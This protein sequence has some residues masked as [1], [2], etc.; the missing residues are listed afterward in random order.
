MKKKPGGSSNEEKRFAVLRRLVMIGQPATFMDLGYIC[1]P[2]TIRT[3]AIHGVLDVHIALKPKGVEEYEKGVA[4]RKKRETKARL[5]KTKNLYPQTLIP[6]QI[7]DNDQ[8][9]GTASDDGLNKQPPKQMEA[10]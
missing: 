3:L 4:L 9:S 1:G 6:D 2:E 5:A 10:A 7:G 8:I